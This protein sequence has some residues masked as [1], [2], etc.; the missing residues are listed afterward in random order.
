LQTLVGTSG[1][2]YAPWKGSFYPDKL[3]AARMLSY[4]AGRF[5]AVEIN[6]TFYRMPAPE[7]L[8]KWAGET[9]ERFRFALK[10][11]RRITHEKKLA[12]TADTVARLF[13]LGAELGPKLG[14]VLFQLPPFLRKDLG[15][16][17]TF[18][19]ELPAG[20]RAAFEFRHESWFA[21]EV[22]DA[23]RAKGAALC[24]AE[25]EDLATPLEGTASWGYLRLRRQDYGEADLDR[26]A[27]RIRAQ[28]WEAVYVFFKHED[29]GKGPQLADQLL[30]RLAT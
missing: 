4:Y 26:W 14:P 29:E 1:Y 12:D 25:A 10:S 5:A 7:M 24:V 20:A 3:P 13:Q 16:L 28:S 27:E 23:L 9:P 11:P 19:A 8:R 21:P 18:L 30:S 2:S 6:N 22:Y 15:R 17:E